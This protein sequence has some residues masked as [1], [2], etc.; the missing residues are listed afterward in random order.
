MPPH[1]RAR[2][3]SE[4]IYYFILQYGVPIVRLV[5]LGGIVQIGVGQRRGARHRRGQLI[6]FVLV[7]TVETATAATVSVMVLLGMIMC[8]V[9]TIVK[10]SGISIWFDFIKIIV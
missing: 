7:A 3:W 6:D 1:R 2:S 10:S 9:V 8:I 5:L 4:S